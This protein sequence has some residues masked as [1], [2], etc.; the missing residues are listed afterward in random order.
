MDDSS[1]QYR[2]RL[3]QIN[4]IKL[5]EASGK[6]IDRTGDKFWKSIENRKDNQKKTR[7]SALGM[8]LKSMARYL[9]RGDSSVEAHERATAD[10]AGEH[11]QPGLDHLDQHYTHLTGSEAPGWYSKENK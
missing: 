3:A 5:N 9:S 11:G 1:I 4:G 2:I 10:V 6:Q 7:A 8:Y